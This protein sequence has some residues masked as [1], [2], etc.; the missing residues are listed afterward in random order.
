MS[1]SINGKV[2]VDYNTSE[3]KK[4]KNY[5]IHVFGDILPND[6]DI[7]QTYEEALK[8]MKKLPQLI[9]SANNGKG[10]PLRYLMVP[11]TALEAYLKLS[12]IADRMVKSIDEQSITR[13][14]R[15]FDDISS[16]KQQLYDLY[17]YLNSHH[18]CVPYDRLNSVADM[19]GRVDSSEAKLRYGIVLREYLFLIKII[20]GLN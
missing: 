9:Q 12:N 15:V 8:L 5:K 1:L 19:K 14:V 20:L 2:S 17:D 10:K 16:M 18:Y 6:E 13:F 11:L 7:P 4:E 3:S